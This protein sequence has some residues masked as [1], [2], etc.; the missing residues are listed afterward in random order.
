LDLA[1][2]RSYLTNI[3][4]RSQVQKHEKDQLNASVVLQ[5]NR[6]KANGNSPYA[7]PKVV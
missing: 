1:V 5:E 3:N 4:H 6:N 7:K 2:Q